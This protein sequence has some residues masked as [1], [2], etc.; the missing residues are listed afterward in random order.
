MFA[1]Y[2][3]G[4]GAILMLHH[5]R[6]APYRRFLPNEHLTVSPDFLDKTLTWMG[7]RNI[8]VISM[9]EVAL[10]LKDPQLAPN[11]RRFVAITFDDAYRDNLQF[12]L[13]V[14]EKHQA[15]FT[16]YVASGLVEGLADVWWGEY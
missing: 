16:V 11:Q 6:D 14:L 8:D 15:P 13:P 9:D 5:V 3:A 10:R 1:P 7:E 12:A 4:V 2:C